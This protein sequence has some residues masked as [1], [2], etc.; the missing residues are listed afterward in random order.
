MTEWATNFGA[1]D[2]KPFSYLKCLLLDGAKIMKH[3]VSPDKPWFQFWPEGVPKA[4]DYPEIPLFQLLPRAAEM[5]PESTAFS[6]RAKRLSYGELDELTN[7]LA[8]GLHSLGVIK[9]DKVTIFLENGLEFIIGYYGILKAGGT[10]TLA[11]PLFR[12]M[13]LEHH[14]NDTA[15]KTIITNSCLYPLVKEVQAQ[16]KM[17][18]II[19]ADVKRDK[20]VI[21]LEEILTNCPPTPPQFSI[22]PRENVAAIVYTGGTTGFPR[23]V[24]LTH[25]NLVANA[26]QNAAW[27]EWTHQDVIVGVLPFY[28]SWGS[29][30]C[31]NSPIYSGARVVILPR[32]DAE[33]LLTTS[34]REG[35][36]IIYGAASMFT[37]LINNQ[38]LTKYNLATLRY[39]KAGA[40]PIPPEVKKR[41]EQL[42]NVEMILGYGLSEASPE[43]HNSP[44]HR[45]K[46]GTIGIPI[47]DTDARIVDEETGKTELPPGQVGELIIRGPQV[48]KGYLNRPDET[49]EALRN[50]WLY[51][52][53][54]ATM[55]EE[56]YFQIIDRK[57]ETINYKGYS[58]APAE[59]EAILYE[60]PAVK[61]CAVVGKPDILAGEIPKAYVVLRT[62]YTVVPEELI[63]FCVGRIAPYKYI[64]E[65]EFIEEIPKTPVGKVLRRVLKDRERL[66]KF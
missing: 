13:E 43:T 20:G 18:T 36:T 53:D 19:V 8:A 29:C 21:P 42:T 49:Q 14:L 34:E 40:M 22:K 50:G 3:H 16:T 45:V 59:V 28:H 4:L 35:A 54:L 6:C 61:Q 26:M 37:T 9:G 55:D 56:G 52:G 33:E 2:K 66:T 12:Q 27:F 63:K 46:S 11:N 60:H 10:V 39:V 64:R 38:N 51:T 30:T 65:V 47:I 24:L 57:K 7:K 1:L 25:Y 31:L 44:P 62:G 41:W 17:K 32:F 15:A 48:M 5:W 23:G 58:I